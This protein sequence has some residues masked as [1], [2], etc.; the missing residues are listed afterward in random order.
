MDVRAD[1]YSLGCTFYF[2]LAGRPPFPDG[3]WE[4]KLVSHRKVE[5]KPIEQIRPDVPAGV[6]AILRKMMAKRP[7]DRYSAPASVADALTSFSGMSAPAPMPAVIPM[8]PPPGGYEP[9]WTLGANSTVVPPPG[10][11][12]PGYPATPPLG[13]TVLIPGQHTPSPTSGPTL[14]K[15]RKW[16]WIGLFGGSGAVVGLT[17]LLL[18]VFWP[19]SDDP[20]KKG[21]ERRVKDRKSP[22]DGGREPQTPKETPR[23]P[24][25]FAPPSGP[26]LEGGAPRMVK[27]I[28][29]HGYPDNLALSIAFLPDGRTGVSRRYSNVYI[30]DL[31]DYIQ[32]PL[33]WAIGNGASGLAIVSP[34]GKRI[35]ANSGSAIEVFDGKT[36][37]KDG[38]PISLFG[39]C[40]ALT[41]S[42]DSK[43]LSTA[44][45]VDQKGRIRF[46]D[47]E[48]R[49][50]KKTIE[51]DAHVVSVAFSPD[52]RL[53]AAS[54]GGLASMNI[55]NSGDKRIS[56]YRADD[57]NLVRQLDGHPKAMAWVAFFADGKR[58]IS[59]SPFDGTLRVWNVDE[60]DSANVG[61]S[62][63]VIQAGTS[64]T[65]LTNISEA[66]DPNF[67]T[68]GTFWPW[69]RALT[70]HL[71]GGIVLWDMETGEKVLRFKNPSERAHSYATSVAISPDGH[72][73]LAAFNDSFVYLYRLPPPA[74]R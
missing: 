68:C 15:S 19:K 4:E 2:M 33:P 23:F 48:E 38:P 24:P 66:K 56:V 55:V 60:A 61:K 72:H 18:F 3:A 73:A 26:V 43:I 71:D 13:A 54:K 45:K 63:K 31:T 32:R 57:G 42:P 44:E 37:K 27:K 22:S 7:E 62:M 21:D 40:T 49:D 39:E 70:A 41:F 10:P 59:A 14:S 50:Q 52:G 17:I 1:I 16:I 5:P 65:N 74:G 20:N 58:L 6:G 29:G 11:T 46:W 8:G 51:L 9:G 53:L 12:N 34:D 30:W 69:G 35:A 67:M 47:A 36:Y 25:T 64:A 28:A